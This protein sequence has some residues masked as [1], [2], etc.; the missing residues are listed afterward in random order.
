MVQAYLLALAFYLVSQA[1]TPENLNFDFDHGFS[2]LLS[3]FIGSTGGI[4]LVALVS[5]YG[6][7]FV[8]SILYADPWHMV[9]SSWAYF[10]G[11]PSTINVLMVYA[12]CNWHDVSW[13][14]KG[15]D[16]QE[17]LP[18]AQTKKG[19]EMPFVEELEKPQIDIDEQFAS[20]VKRALTP[21]KEPNDNE[22]MALDDSYKAFRTN[23][24]LLWTF[25][26]GLL[27]LCINNISIS[28]LCLTVCLADICPWLQW[29]TEIVNLDR[30]HSVVLQ[31]YLM[32]YFW[33]FY[34]PVF[35]C[36]LL[37]SEDRGIMLFFQALILVY[38]LYTR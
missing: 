17:K 10:V 25:S 21:W 5:V 22:G 32:G 4:V 37:P 26:N 24:V 9:T 34:L 36:S 30:S 13:G 7:Y 38:K 20:T 29:L 18:S 15:S 23:L 19:D 8:A 33:S 16:A 27:A 3:G 31:M 28:R 14:T 2:A 12:F 35:G 6:V 11:M 1:L